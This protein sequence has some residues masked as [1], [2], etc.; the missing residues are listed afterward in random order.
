M[1][2][3]L[4]G[5][6][7][8]KDKQSVSNDIVAEAISSTTQR[9][10][11]SNTNSVDQNAD[12]DVQASTISIGETYSVKQTAMLDVKSASKVVADSQTK[13]EVANSI[14]NKLTDRKLLPS[15]GDEQKIRNNVEVSVRNHMTQENVNRVMNSVNQDIETEIQGAFIGIGTSYNF[16]QVVNLTSQAMANSDITQ[17]IAQDISN[18]LGQDAV[19]SGSSYAIWLIGIFILLIVVAIG[20]GTYMTFS[21]VFTGGDEIDDGP[22]ELDNLI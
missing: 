2:D 12:V 20:V 22:S 16:S 3:S 5:M 14:M 15:G 18:D 10:M 8:G 21:L 6:I 19:K 13:Q 17:E 11:Q 7:F 9:V 1:A 4:Y